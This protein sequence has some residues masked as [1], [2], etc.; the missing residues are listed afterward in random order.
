MSASK[1]SLKPSVICSK[2]SVSSTS[3]LDTFSTWGNQPIPAPAERRTSILERLSAKSV[4]V[5]LGYVVAGRPSPCF[6]WQ[7]STSGNGRGGGYGRMS[8][9]GFT[10]ATHLVSFTHFFGYIPGKKQ[11]DHLCNNR[12]CWNPQHLELVS[13]L[14]NQRR[15]SQRTI[16]KS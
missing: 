1:L 11:V 9:D 6:I 16:P 8:L 15:R 3:V 12:L 13:H 2:P 10:V 14:T 5:D 4:I 7:G